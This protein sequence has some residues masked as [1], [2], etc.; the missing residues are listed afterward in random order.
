MLEDPASYQEAYSIL[1][2]ASSSNLNALAVRANNRSYYAEGIQSV[3]DFNFITNDISHDINIGLRYHKDEIDRFQ[4]DDLYAM[5][6]GVMSLTT[7]GVPGTESNL[8]KSAKA[9]ATYINID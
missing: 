1:T 2:G 5:N 3:L 8:V 6:N 9:F 7:A 4:W